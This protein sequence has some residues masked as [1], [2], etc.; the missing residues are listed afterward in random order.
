MVCHNCQFLN[1]QG[2]QSCLNCGSKMDEIPY[3][4]RK[5]AGSPE[6]WPESNVGAEGT[7]MSEPDTGKKE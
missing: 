3:S 2:A 4:E 1:S 7:R 5:H 6:E